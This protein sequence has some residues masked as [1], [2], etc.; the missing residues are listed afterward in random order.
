MI[1]R[2][3]EPFEKNVNKYTSEKKIVSFV[4]I[5]LPIHFGH[6]SNCLDIMNND[7]LITSVHN[8]Y[9]VDSRS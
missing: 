4:F 6:F 1:F 3:D 2:D 8:I 5:T 9:H 7:Q